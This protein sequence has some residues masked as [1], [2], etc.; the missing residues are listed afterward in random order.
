MALLPVDKDANGKDIVRAVLY[1]GNED[2]KSV[3]SVSQMLVIVTD[4]FS[5]LKILAQV[6]KQKI[7]HHSCKEGSKFDIELQSS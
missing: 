5:D 3:I 2:S 1:G 7:Y 4:K 6:K